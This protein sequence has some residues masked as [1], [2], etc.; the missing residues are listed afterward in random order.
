MVVVVMMRVVAVV[1]MTMMVVLLQQVHLEELLVLVVEWV[2]V[3]RL[4]DRWDLD[5]ASINPNS[6]PKKNLQVCCR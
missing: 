4:F 2:A 6:P 1:V 3:G 5:Q